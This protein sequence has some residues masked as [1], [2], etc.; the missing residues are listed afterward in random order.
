M[1][2]DPSNSFQGTNDVDPRA[3]VVDA[4]RRLASRPIDARARTTRASGITSRGAREG[5]HRDERRDAT[6][7]RLIRVRKEKLK[8]DGYH[9]ASSAIRALGAPM[10]DENAPA[11]MGKRGTGAGGVW[12]RL[13]DS[14]RGWDKSRL[15][16]SRPRRGRRWGTS[17]IEDVP[18]AVGRR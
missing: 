11:M 4:T 10:T 14:G 8:T 13:E 12:G 6:R 1:S 18:R 7:V 9:R 2:H 3:I 17:R 15:E 16:T 5:A